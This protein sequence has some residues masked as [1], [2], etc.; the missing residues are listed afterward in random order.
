MF[1]GGLR[2]SGMKMRK[3]GGKDGMGFRLWEARIS[4]ISGTFGKRKEA[5]VFFGGFDIQG[6]SIC[7]YFCISLVDNQMSNQKVLISFPPLHLPSKEPH[8]S[9][10]SLL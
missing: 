2:G 7:Q 10:K 6:L 1:L 3:W 5:L 9:L 4:L 8:A